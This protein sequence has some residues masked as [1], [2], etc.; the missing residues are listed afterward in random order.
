MASEESNKFSSNLK[1]PPLKIVLSSHQNN[2]VVNTSNTEEDH[3]KSSENEDDSNDHLEHKKILRRNSQD[4]SEACERN[5]KKGSRGSSDRNES[6]SGQPS[7]RTAEF[8]TSSSSSSSSDRSSTA[9]PSSESESMASNST[10]ISE[11]HQVKGSKTADLKDDASTG[12][13]DRSKFGVKVTSNDRQSTNNA[14]LTA[15]KAHEV[16]IEQCNDSTTTKEQI[17]NANQRITRSSQRAAQQSKTETS[18][19]TSNETAGDEPV[20]SENQDK[21]KLLE[22]VGRPYIPKKFALV[23]LKITDLSP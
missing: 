15:K 8:S 6:E 21:G 13:Q 22:C 12:R 18:N 20:V 10:I 19:E 7:S 9:T 3:F 11:Q 16:N 14:A 4:I 1:V 17:L 23:R 2:A 5:L